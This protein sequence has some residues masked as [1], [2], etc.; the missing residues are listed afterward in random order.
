MSKILDAYLCES[1]FLQP[2]G[3]SID[4]DEFCFGAMYI[5]IWG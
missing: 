2:S 5:Y 4:E 1:R 3:S